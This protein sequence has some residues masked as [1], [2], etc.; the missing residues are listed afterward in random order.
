MFLTYLV[1][2]LV[3]APD[4]IGVPYPALIMSASRALA[5]VVIHSA[6]TPGL[7]VSQNI[8]TYD[9]TRERSSVSAS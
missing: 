7:F 5:T 3:L 2:A 6:V 4:D 8:L 9:C 1:P